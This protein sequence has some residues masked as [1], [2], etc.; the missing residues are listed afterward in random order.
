MLSLS[1]YCDLFCQPTNLSEYLL[2]WNPRQC[3]RKLSGIIIR[4]I[5]CFPIWNQSS[6]RFHL[7][8]VILI[9]TKICVNLKFCNFQEPL[10]VATA[11]NGVCDDGGPGSAQRWCRYATGSF[12]TSWE[13]LKL[14]YKNNKKC[15]KTCFQTKICVQEYY[16]QM[17]FNNIKFHVI[18]FENYFRLWRLLCYWSPVAARVRGLRS[19]P[20][21]YD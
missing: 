21:C 1:S 14:N 4:T 13:K 12:D 7:E 2:Q 9:L 18:Y 11:N 3:L 20:F 5:S 19:W 17:P 16:F 15:I 10:V 8:K 6:I